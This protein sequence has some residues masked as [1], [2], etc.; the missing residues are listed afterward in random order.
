MLSATA[1]K[2]F[3]EKEKENKVKL[4]ALQ[5]DVSADLA[6]TLLRGLSVRRPWTS[7]KDLDS[8]L[9][10]TSKILDHWIYMLQYKQ[11]R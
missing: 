5:L 3:V 1:L 7:N 9:D 11:S 6:V 10:R 4:V 2:Y 8:Y